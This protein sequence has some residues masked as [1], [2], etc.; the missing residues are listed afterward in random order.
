N[1]WITNGTQQT[2]PF[3]GFKDQFFGLNLQPAKNLKWNV[4]YYL[5]Q[6]HPDIALAPNSM[7]PS[8]P[9]YHARPF[10]PIPNA[11]SGKL[12]IFDSYVTWTVSP[13]LTLAVVRRLCD[14]AAGEVLGAFTGDWRC[15]LCQLSDYSSS[16]FEYLSDRGGLF[17]GTTQA[18]KETTVTLEQKIVD[19][20]LI[21]QEWRRDF[22]NQP[23]FLT[24]TLGILKREQ[25]TATMGVVWWFGP[26]RARW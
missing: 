4:N 3:N 7:D 26:K 21:R 19:G 14:P 1:Y 24:D 5:G 20:L 15:R 23:Y 16:G 22:S 12:H 2:E 25:N 6:E 18:L 10:V 17:S 11:P 13:K 9:T 8:L